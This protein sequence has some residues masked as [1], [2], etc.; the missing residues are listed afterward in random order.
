[1]PRRD[2]A[3]LLLVAWLAPAAGVGAALVGAGA[4][5]IAGVAVGAAVAGTAIL[6]AARRVQSRRLESLRRMARRQLRALESGLPGLPSAAAAEAAPA[7]L[8]RGVPEAPA[9][10]GAGGAGGGGGGGGPAAGGLEADGSAAGEDGLQALAVEMGLV[11]QRITAQVKEV[12]KKTRNLE[13]L[14]D[15]LDEPVFA[16]GAQETVLLCNR[17]AE[18]L[19]G[20]PAGTLRG[21]PV[22]EVFTRRELLDMHAAARAGQSRRRQI[23]LT[24]P[25]GARTFQVSA[26][27]LPA[28]W[29]E[30]VFGAVLVLRDVTELAQAVQVKTDFVANASHELRTPVSAIRT[31]IETLQDGAKDEPP[32][33]DRLL[34]VCANHVQRLEE[35]VR[36]LMDLSRLETPDMPV[37]IDAVP[38]EEMCESLQLIFE[39]VCAERA[40]SLEFDFDPALGG[41][42]TDPKLLSLILRNLVDNASKFAFEGSAITIAARRLRRDAAGASAG[43]PVGEIARFQVRDRGVGIPLSQ[44]ERVFERFYQ[45]DPA[46]SGFSPRR[47]TG[48]GLAIVKH[49]C[50]ALGGKVGLESV[51]G[52]GTTVWVEIP[53]DFEP[54][55]APAAAPGSPGSP[56]SLS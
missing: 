11:G 12:A 25:Q 54:A 35:M 31:A 27:P 53:A 37:R 13:A 8:G 3:I 14:I 21:R 56:A 33:R 30:G 19:I 48:L 32:M 23:R 9:G 45:V 50:K 29:G 20:V 24:T 18:A 1:M 40:L 49:A 6:L 28:A 43:A 4:S 15:G 10:G 2:L 42:R 46:R 22:R 36:D 16:T 39:P 55:A 41:L 5:V 52:E 47:G 34:D 38:L 7:E 44:Q 26:T 17:P 51:W